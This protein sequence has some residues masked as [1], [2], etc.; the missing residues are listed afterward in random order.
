MLAGLAGRSEIMIMM[1]MDTR[2]RAPE[3]RTSL[4]QTALESGRRPT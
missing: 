3:E 4:F 1:M 2:L